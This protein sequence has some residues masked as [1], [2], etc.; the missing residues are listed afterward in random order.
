M[1]DPSHR[2]LSTVERAYELA[3]SG[4]CRSVDD[5][6]RKLTAERYESVQAHLSGASI[7]R[8]L[9]A[10]CKAATGGQ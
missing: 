7:K 9:V 6:R 5:I 3:R 10:L 8:D 1:T 2:Q 4:T